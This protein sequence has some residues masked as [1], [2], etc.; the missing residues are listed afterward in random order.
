MKVKTI[1]EIADMMNG[2]E[3]PIHDF[4]DVFIQAKES[5]IVIVY[6]ASDDL[7]EIFGA[8]YEECGAYNGTIVHLNQSGIIQ[9]L[10]DDEACPYFQKELKESKHSIEAVWC[11][12]DMPET[13]WRIS[14]TMPFEEFDIMEEGE[15]YCRGIV[16]SMDSL[17]Q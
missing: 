2:A 8:I 17:K 4:N 15:V 9:N 12:Q 7:L 16:F 11:P 10:C 5:N 14:G 1:K 3:Y 6:G 13:S